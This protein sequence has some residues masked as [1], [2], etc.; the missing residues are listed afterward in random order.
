MEPAPPRARR[1][2]TFLATVIGGLLVCFD[3]S[4]I[5][6]V[7]QNMPMYEVAYSLLGLLLGIAMLTGAYLYKRKEARSWL[8]VIMVSSL[9][10]LFLA[11]TIVSAFG[12]LLG[13]ISSI[14]LVTRK[15]IRGA[16]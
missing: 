1:D 16:S 4:S 7:G 6:V 15:R 11:V 13:S 2:Y 9:L 10:G 8:Y 5:L 12:S 3:Y 14:Y